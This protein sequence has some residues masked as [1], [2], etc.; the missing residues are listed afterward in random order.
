[1]PDCVKLA[2]GAGLFDAIYAAVAMIAMAPV[3]AYLGELF[4]E[5][6]FAGGIVQ[7]LAVIGMILYG[8][9]QMRERLPHSSM[10]TKAETG[11][12]VWVWLRSH[13]P[14]FVGIGF[15]LANLANPTFVPAL[16]ALSAAVHGWHLFEPNILNSVLFAIGFGVGNFLWMLTL[17]KVVLQYRERMT[18]R[19]VHRIQQVA[20][21]ALAGFGAFYG[22]RILVTVVR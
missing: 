6:P 12:G 8:L 5:Y 20:G 9:L 10:E 13:G 16:A 4:N 1:L 17:A 19:L 7:V 15:A 18:P 14:F 3:A 2:G 11:T 21:A 22:L